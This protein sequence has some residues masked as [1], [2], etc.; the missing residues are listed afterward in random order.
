MTEEDNVA[1]VRSPPSALEKA[2]P[3]AKRILSGI[4]AD[5]LALAHAQSLSALQFI[6]STDLESWCQ[7]GTSYYYGVGVP[8]DYAQ[9]VHWFRKA[10]EQ[11]HAEAQDRLGF[12]YA[13][14]HGVP[15]DYA[16]AVHWYRKAVAQGNTA[17]P[18]ST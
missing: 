4:V 10:A 2:Q 15:Q 18:S 13:E 5:A 8:Q 16:Q 11:G 6:A 14:G 12:C 9:A 17:M 7:K 1:L 3:G